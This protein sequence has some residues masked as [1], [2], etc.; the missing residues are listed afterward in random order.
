[1]AEKEDPKEVATDDEVPLTAMS[2]GSTT[3]NRTGSWK[4]LEPY[5]EDQTPP[6]VDRCPVANDIS[7]LMRLAEEGDFE[8][9]AR[10][11]LQDNPFPSILGRVCSHPCEQPCNRKAM[12]GAVHIQGVERFLGD[13]ALEH[14]LL[15]ELPEITKSSVAVVGA[16]PAGLSAAYFLRMLGHEVTVIERSD[17]IGGLLWRELPSFKV[18]KDVLENELGRFERLG[19][20]FE[21]GKALRKDVKISELRRNYKAVVLA[22][23]LGSPRELGVSGED[24]ASVIDGLEFFEKLQR[25]EKLDLGKQVVVIGGG[26][27]AVDCGRLLLRIGHDVKVIYRRSRK[28][29]LASK[30]AVQEALAEG[31]PI[32]FQSQPVRFVIENDR[33][34]G[35][36]LVKTDLGEPDASKR[37]RAVPIEG[38]EYVVPADAAVVAMG[39]VLELDDC[40]EKLDINGGIE[41]DFQF[42]TSIPRV[43][44]CGDVLGSII[45][46]EDAVGNAV[47]MG[48]KV[49]SEV[50]SD[51]EGGNYIQPDPLKRRG[52]STEIAK[53]KNFNRAYH[54]NEEPSPLEE[55]PPEERVRDMAE[56]FK[57]LREE[58][59]R[60][61][62]ARCIKCGTCIQ[63][64]NCHLFC[65]DAAII[66]RADGTGYEILC[67]YCKGCGVCVEE[68][69]R[70][71]IH[72]RRVSRVTQE[73][74]DAMGEQP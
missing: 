25:G 73:E 66:R 17:R 69:P 34:A 18:S 65:P 26:N 42:H 37:R 23:G 61:E 29:M 15:P 70:G 33:L 51:L 40:D 13:Y 1:M 59:V 32:E 74:V 45:T 8:T 16:G 53:F 11:L 48:R 54:Q 14:Q 67:D 24:H 22:I 43:Y 60:H 50:H 19:I 68:C 58:D 46:G 28:E 38:T 20:R 31:L 21:K 27:I 52:A 39:K 55:R 47:A 62:G 63:C 4:Y 10:F 57:S 41:V 2:L 72:L 35:V 6:C 5:F 9:G 44:A 7:E 12:G 36:E 56:Y 71:A 3:V 64:D 30:L 49:A